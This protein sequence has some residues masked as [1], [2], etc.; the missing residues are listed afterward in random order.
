MTCPNLDLNQFFPKKIRFTQTE[1][2]DECDNVIVMIYH[3]LI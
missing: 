2:I 1:E 3:V